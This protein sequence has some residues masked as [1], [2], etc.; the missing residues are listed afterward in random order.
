V[1]KATFC[2]EFKSLTSSTSSKNN[3]KPDDIDLFERR[4]EDEKQKDVQ[5][6]GAEI[7]KAV[8][9]ET[10]ALESGAGENPIP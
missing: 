9:E 2:D 1:F 3:L 10:K 7:K 5:E 4:L 8:E 6:I